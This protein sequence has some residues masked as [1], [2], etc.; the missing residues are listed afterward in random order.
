MDDPR[1]LEFLKNYK[2]SVDDLK[3]KPPDFY[4][5]NNMAAEETSNQT[6]RKDLM[7][8]ALSHYEEVATRA[9]WHRSDIP[10]AIR[11][12]YA[13]PVTEEKKTA[14][15]CPVCRGN[16]KVPNGFYNQTSGD[17]S[18][19]SITPETCRSCN[20]TGIVWQP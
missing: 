16:G 18:S 10:E 14:V 4:T 13:D 8:E 5:E 15:V 11:A 1:E 9:C 20:G 6:P 7:R 2:P 19:T 12:Y 3:M 17:W